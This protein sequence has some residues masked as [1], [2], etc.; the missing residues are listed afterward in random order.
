MECNHEFAVDASCGGC[1]IMLS[2]LIR[3]QRDEI[4]RASGRVV[5]DCWAVKV[6]TR[7]GTGFEYAK[8]GGGTPFL[9]R[10][11]DQCFM[12]HGDGCVPVSVL[13]VTVADASE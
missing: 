13:V 10:T 11:E 8:D 1:G 12:V 7:D 2:E 4:A 9:H 6:R 3:S 5:A